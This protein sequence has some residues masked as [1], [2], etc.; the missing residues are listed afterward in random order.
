MFAWGKYTQHSI[1][2]VSFPITFTK[3]YVKLNG[4]N[5]NT[6]GN[7]EWKDFGHTLTT[8]GFTVKTSSG[9]YVHH[10]CIIGTKS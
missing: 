1:T 3:V 2:S 6:S 10:Y 7:P 4:T 5:S 8:S 9:T